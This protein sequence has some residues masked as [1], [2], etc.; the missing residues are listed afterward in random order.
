MNHRPNLLLI[1]TDQQ[2]ATMMSGAG[3]LWL[4]T[5][6]MDSLAAEGVRFERA[7]CSN[8]VCIASRFSLFTGRWPSEIG[9]YSNYT[10]ELL[11]FDADR[12][13][14]G[15]GW[16]L[17]AAGYSTFY[18]GKVHL[19]RMNIEE[20]GFE[21]ICRD[22][23]D[24]LAAA[25]ADF[26]RRPPA[27]P[28]CLVAS[29]INP[30][31]I[32]YLAIRDSAQN[33]RERRLLDLGTVE[34]ATLDRALARPSGVNDAAFFRSHAPPLPANF[35]PQEDEPEVIARMLRARP[36]REKARR[37]WS[38][39]RW[40]EHRWA[41][42]RL[43]EFVDAQ[44]GV[45]LD[46]LRATGLDRTTLTVFTSDHGDMD[47]AHGMEHKSTMYEEAARV[48]LLVRPPGGAPPRVDATHGVSN[49]LDLL[50]TLCDFAGAT[51]PAGLPGRSL[52]P[53]IEGARG[54]RWRAA[55][56]MESAIGRAARWGDFKYARYDFSANGEQLYDLA[57]DP[58]ET[59]NFA[60]DPDRRAALAEGRRRFERAFAGVA[61]DPVLLARS[62]DDA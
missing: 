22:E 26:L 33:E 55:V 46:A 47:G 38:A 37:E 28:F 53:L 5:P 43:T 2:S 62:L 60:A 51:P 23:R 57:R 19:P 49:G 1:L 18:G 16:R 27:E 32:C 24:A 61:R 17:R 13:R 59:R 12:R 4:R 36:F 14:D 34:L 44:I 3:N 50:P 58:G 15:L 8:S 35:A 7:Y 54:L 6:A 30:H 25:A 20:V 48:P 21:V 56:P 40:R 9:L 41:Y 42:A 39:E 52:R 11:P 29:F 45:V 31:D 10:A